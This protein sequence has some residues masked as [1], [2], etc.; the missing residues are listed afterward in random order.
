[1]GSLLAGKDFGIE[2]TVKDKAVIK[3]IRKKALNK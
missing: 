1:V 2:N 3:K